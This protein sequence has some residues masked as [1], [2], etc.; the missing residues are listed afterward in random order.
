MTEFK[1]N[2]LLL[3]FCAEYEMKSKWMKPVAFE[4]S[5]SPRHPRPSIALVTCSG[6]LQGS[7]CTL[8]ALGPMGDCHVD[9]CDIVEL[10]LFTRMV[11]IEMECGSDGGSAMVERW[12]EVRVYAMV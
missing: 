1:K 12:F 7:T 10:C 5:S 11:M 2:S 8:S 4:E 3:K 6:Q 9:F